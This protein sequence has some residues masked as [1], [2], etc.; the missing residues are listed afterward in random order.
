MKSDPPIRGRAFTLIELL[1]VIAIIALL[2]GL[3][4]PALG[5]ARDN[6]RAAKCMSQQ[7]SIGL[8]LMIYA[9]TYREY[10]PR[11]SGHCENPAVVNLNNLLKAAPSWTFMLRPILLLA[12]R[13]LS[14]PGAAF[15]RPAQHPLREQRDLVQFTR[16]RELLGQAVDSAFPAR[17]AVRDCLPGVLRR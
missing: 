5:K 6:A 1:V 17:A 9:E 11:E 7:R 16:G 13:V 2:I 15:E 3:M 14:R 4:L 12:L 10:V 8:A